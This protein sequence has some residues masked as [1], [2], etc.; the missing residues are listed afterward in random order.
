L[1][2]ERPHLDRELSGR[3]RIVDEHEAP[4]AQ[5]RPVGQVE[6][7][8]Q[9]VV[10]PTARI[11]DARAPPDPRGAVEVEKPARPVARRVLD[12]EMA[13]QQRL[14]RRPRSAGGIGVLPFFEVRGSR[15]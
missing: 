5:L 4:A 3:N 12:D 14:R 10:L 6:V 7:L 2:L 13:V 11:V 9:R 15:V 1:G 8:G